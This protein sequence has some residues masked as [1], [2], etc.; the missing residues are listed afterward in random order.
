MDEFYLARS[1]A[2][3]EKGR[4]VLS[5]LMEE[6]VLVFSIYDGDL[7]NFVVDLKLGKK[8]AQWKMDL[9]LPVFPNITRGDQ[10]DDHADYNML[11]SNNPKEVAKASQM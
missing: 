4:I 8:R 1:L 5:T 3:S 6:M 9:F 2:Q 11:G 10:N 7:R